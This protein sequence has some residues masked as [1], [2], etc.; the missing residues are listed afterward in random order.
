MRKAFVNYMN[1]K[2]YVRKAFVNYMNFKKLIGI[3]NYVNKTFL[4]VC[5]YKLL[6][7]LNINFIILT[8]F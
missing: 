5:D 6:Y 8:S 3:L 4:I 7:Y 2:L 1:F